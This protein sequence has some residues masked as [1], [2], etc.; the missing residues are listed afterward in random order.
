MVNNIIKQKSDGILNKIRQNIQRFY[1]YATNEKYFIDFLI[2]KY[3]IINNQI[4]I[5][6]NIFNILINKGNNILNIQLNMVEQ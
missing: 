3:Y 1:D 6:F 5:F 4:I 2:K